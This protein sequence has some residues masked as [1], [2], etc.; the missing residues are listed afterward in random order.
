MKATD[1]LTEEHRIILKVLACT[2]KIVAEA[3][4]TGK[5]NADAANAA[6]SFFRNFADGCHHAKEEDRLFVV[7]QENGIPRE[8]GPIGVMLMEHDHGRSCVRGMAQAVENAAQGDETALQNFAENARNFVALLT[9]H[10]AKEDQVLFPMAG[11][12]LDASKAD[13]LISD[14][15]EIESAA[16]GN[17]HAEYI[18]IARQLCEQY[19]IAFVDQA[20]IQTLT[21]ELM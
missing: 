10:I 14:F 13:N 2:E 16:G 1:I 17:R 12:I 21:T 19:D 8:G 20:D 5:L 15:K 7:M 3:D 6:I 9:D 18:Q 11:Q 4:S